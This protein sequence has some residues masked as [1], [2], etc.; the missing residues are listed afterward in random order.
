MLQFVWHVKKNI[1][2]HSVENVI[3]NI[4]GHSVTPGGTHMRR[5][6]HP[7]PQHF[8][9]STHINHKLKVYCLLRFATELIQY[10]Q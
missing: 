7:H 6:P 1:P 10:I 9:A 8:W 4:P 2:G 5:H 3:I